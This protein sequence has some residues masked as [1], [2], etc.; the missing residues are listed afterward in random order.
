MKGRKAFYLIICLLL[1]GAIGVLTN[2]KLRDKDAGMAALRPRIVAGYAKLPLF[3]EPNRGQADSEVKFLSR[4]RGYTLFLTPREA[5]LS[6]RRGEKGKDSEVRSDARPAHFTLLRMKLVGANPEP[7]VA[8]QDALPGKSNYFHGNDPGKWLTRVPHYA[9]VKYEEVYPGIDL[10][11]YGTERHQ[12]EYDFVVSPG[13][14][15]Q[16]I[17]LEIEGAGRMTLN[18]EGALLLRTSG[19]EV[20][21]QAPFIYQ[22]I[23]G[24]QKAV[25]GGYLI[26]AENQVAFS[27]REYDEGKPLVIDPTLSYATYLGGSGADGGTHIAAD[28]SGN[29]YVTG[30]TSS[31][32]FPR[33]NPAQDVFGGGSTDIFVTKLNADGSALTYSTFLGGSN[34]E[35]SGGGIAVDESGSAYI[36]GTTASTD[37][38]TANPPQDV[39]KGLQDAFV[40]KLSAD[41]SSLVYS[42][43]LGGSGSVENGRDIV[44]DDSGNAYV[45]GFTDSIDFPTVNPPFQNVNGGGRD[46]FVTKLNPNGTSLVYSTYLGG[47]GDDGG[48]GI[49]VDS[50]D[51]A[52][53]T[54]DTSSTTTFPTSDTAP[55]QSLKG[56]QDAFVTK[57]SADGA[58]LGFSTYLGGSDTDRG[59]GIAVDVLGNAYVTGITSSLDFPTLNPVQQTLG[60]GVDAFVTKMNL[61]GTALEYST[62]LG[63]S[64]DE[65]GA[66]N[67]AIAVDTSA[68]A[69]VA[70]TTSSTNFPLANELQAIP[71]GSCNAFVT[72]YSTDGAALAFSTYLGGGACDLGESIALDASGNAYVTGNTSSPDFPTTV[73]P[74]QGILGGV[75]DAFVAKIFTDFSL[76]I[77]AGS[78]ASAT[79]SPGETATYDL[80][81]TPDGFS[82]TISLSCSGQ[83]TGATCRTVPVSIELDGTNTETFRVSVTTTAPALVVPPVGQR[84]RHPWPL[85]PS[86]FLAMLGLAEAARRGGAFNLPAGVRRATV[87]MGVTLL[88]AILSVSCSNE[89]G[90]GLPPTPPGTSTL[91]IDATSGGVTRTI[92]LTLVVN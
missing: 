92:D 55:Q 75:S 26:L 24:S 49:A 54:G 81:L 40:T 68:S 51:N 42:T 46:A 57:L 63:G 52:Y 35:F 71:A 88:F 16:S 23:F 1:A 14:D 18:D 79:V 89:I 65:T 41:G 21:W 27:V 29:A 43:Y 66:G 33:L 4:G 34:N 28:S 67:I 78:Q 39:L 59:H 2:K 60:G 80:I 91:T 19:G 47:T 73:S 48:E 84:S 76:A 69:Y 45:T 25:D 17:R 53:V 44:V 70:G 12:L 74:L 7:K 8:G 77:D 85:V 22:E 87:V 58:S 9:R 36:T 62:Y 83:P 3:F 72:K 20:A 64:N 10:V 56:R 32:D 15:P 50:S 38:P 37:F 31:A 90:A 13:A 30:T 86:L 11:Y 5:V 82:G 6:L 61:N